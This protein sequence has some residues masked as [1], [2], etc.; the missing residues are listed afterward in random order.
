MDRFLSMMR[1]AILS[2]PADL[3]PE[4][5]LKL[6]MLPVVS[7]CIVGFL[8]DAFSLHTLALSEKVD[9][10]VPSPANTHYAL[11]FDEAPV[12]AD[13][14]LLP[15][16]YCKRPGSS[17]DG[18]ALHPVIYSCLSASKNLAGHGGYV[19]GARL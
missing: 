2:F 10:T 19:I 11:V 16:F 13:D 5:V 18:S 3:T 7:E 8:T 4:Q 12:L 17:Y 1:I 14:E 15:H 9:F 6:Q